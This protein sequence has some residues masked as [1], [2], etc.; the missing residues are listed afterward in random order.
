MEAVARGEEEVVY[1]LEHPHVYT[2]GRRG[3]EE[4]LPDP[5]TSGDIVPVFRINRGGDVTY[6]G[7]GQLV[8]YLH[9]DLTRRERDVHRYLRRLEELLIEIA[10]QFGVQAFRREGLTGVWTDRGKLASIG[11]GV[12]RW[13]TMHGFALNVDPDLRYFQCIHPCG[14]PGCPMTS[15]RLESARDVT[16]S[17]VRETAAALIPRLFE[18][19]D[20]RP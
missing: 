7:P 20:G 17:A 10:R 4:N 19:G 18:P 6:H 2:V 8:G 5:Q 16:M 12:R 3:K 15:L 13:I 1:L 11:V 14:I 9:L